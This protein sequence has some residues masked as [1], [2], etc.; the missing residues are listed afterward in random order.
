VDTHRRLSCFKGMW[1][2]N[3]WDKKCIILTGKERESLD[4]RHRE[5]FDLAER[6]Q[7][8]DDMGSEV[9]RN[10]AKKDNGND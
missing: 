3:D 6:C 10:E 4:I 7:Y 9:I 2:K 1:I 5:T 8:Y